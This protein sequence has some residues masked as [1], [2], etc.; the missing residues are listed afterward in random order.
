MTY[1]IWAGDLDVFDHQKLN[2]RISEAIAN[3]S[4]PHTSNDDIGRSEALKFRKELWDNNH[5]KYS[6]SHIQ[7][8][9]KG[10]FG[11]PYTYESFLRK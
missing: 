7:Y 11:G 8:M 9:K 4:C 3:N 2:A 6:H 10:L 1:P 5:H